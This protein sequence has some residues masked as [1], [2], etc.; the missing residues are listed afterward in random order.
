MVNRTALD[1][2][3]RRRMY[4]FRHGSVDYIDASGAWVPDPDVVSL[5]ERG[6]VQ[7]SA[8]AKLFDGVH[9]DRA[10]CSGLPRTVQTGEAVL[11]SRDVELERRPS[12]EEIRPQKGESAGGYDIVSDIAFSHWRAH[13]PEATFLRGERY[14][15]FYAR[16]VHAIEAVLAEDD[17]NNLAVFAHGGTNSAV[18]GWVTGVGL[19]GF[20]LIDQATCCLNIID[21]DVSGDGKVL[22][23]VVRGMNITADDPVMRHR[24]HGDMEALAKRMLHLNSG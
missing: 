9:V 21:F 5:N 19:D 20:G 14:G 10:I 22:R 11:G 7:A 16:I 3:R 15:D 23:K 2:A 8:M 4:L 6:V 17:W 13:D 18:L 1:G 24:D 12:L